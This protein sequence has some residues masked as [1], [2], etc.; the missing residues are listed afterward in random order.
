MGRLQVF[1]HSISPRFD[2]RKIAVFYLHRIAEP[3]CRDRH[4]DDRNI[5]PWVFEKQLES[6]LEFAELIPL[7]DIAKFSGR[8][9]RPGAKPAVALTFDDGYLN[10]RKHALPILERLRVPATVLVVTGS[11]GSVR[12]QPFDRWALRNKSHV[13]ADCWQMMDWDDLEACA[14]S[15]L[16]TVGSHSHRHDRGSGLDRASIRDEVERSAAMLRS[17]LGPEHARIYAY[18]FGNSYLGDV[19]ED[20]V[21]A[22]RSAGFEIGLTTDSGLVCAKSDPL[23]LPRLELHALD[24]PATI[25]AKT[26]GALLPLYAKDM[27]HRLERRLRRPKRIREPR[28]N[29][30]SE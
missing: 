8:P 16:V 14:A 21:H 27:F 11:V 12:P 6:L 10:F 22:V 26:A 4:I 23:R 20:Y 2:T 17:R 18:P 1:L 29:A 3:G 9:R 24:T 7:A 13:P 25:R 15:G 30:A 5:R 19:S 28:I